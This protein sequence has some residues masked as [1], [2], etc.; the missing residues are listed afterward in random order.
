MKMKSKDKRNK[1]TCNTKQ[2]SESKMKTKIKDTL[3]E[4]KRRHGK[5]EN[6]Q[7][8]HTKLEDM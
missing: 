2:V 7:Q 5:N 4:E 3:L 1:K 6:K 8:R